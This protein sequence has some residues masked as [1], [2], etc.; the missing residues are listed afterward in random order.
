MAKQ[1]D[2]QEFSSNKQE[3]IDREALEGAE[4]FQIIG[5]NSEATT[6]MENTWPVGGLYEFLEVAKPMEIVSTSTDDNING[7]GARMMAIGGLDG[8]FNSISEII[9]LNGTSPVPTQNNY[10][11]INTFA[12]IDA[13][14]HASTALTGSNKGDIDVRVIIGSVIQS[15]VLNTVGF[16]RN[17]D[18]KFT[19][20][21]G[22]IALL[23]SVTI[24]FE[25]SKTGN[26]YL[27]GV[28]NAPDNAWSTFP[29][30]RLLGFLQKSDNVQSFIFNEPVLIDQM[31]DIWMTSEMEGQT[32]LINVSYVMQVERKVWEDD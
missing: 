14:E 20:P 31:T 17:S 19:I 6:S 4:V 32:G 1:R 27:W 15:R 13:G 25:S 16:G 30:R 21:R 18:G 12:I 23:R 9:E 29:P 10:M 22:K 11:R 26:L 3:L 24:N 2:I 5:H 7:I 8:N 28:A